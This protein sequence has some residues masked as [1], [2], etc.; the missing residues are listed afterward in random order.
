MCN[1]NTLW[2]ILETKKFQNVGVDLLIKL[3]IE[4]IDY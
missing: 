3:Y 1:N 4:N 2:F